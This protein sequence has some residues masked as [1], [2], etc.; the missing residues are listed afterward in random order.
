MA[1]TA[2]EAQATA[3]RQC[4][5][6]T[7]THPSQRSSV[8]V[9]TDRTTAPMDLNLASNI[10]FGAG[11]QENLQQIGGSRNV[12]YN[13]IINYHSGRAQEPTRTSPP[14]SSTVPFHR[15]RNFVDRPELEI[16][17]EKLSVW[18]EKVALVGIGGVGKSQLAIE[19]CYRVRERSPEVWTFWI[20]ASSA[21]RFDADIRKLACDAEIPGWDD[22]KADAFGLV[23]SWLRNERNGKW[24]LVLDNVDDASF[25][26]DK[27]DENDKNARVRMAY[28]PPCAHGS[29]LITS[30]SRAA[31]AR[32]ADECNIVVVNRMGEAAALALLEKKLGQSPAV[33]DMQK[34]ADA[35]GYMPLALAQAGAYIKQRGSSYSIGHYLTRFKKS[36]KSQT[37]LLTSG[38]KELRRDEEAQDSII[39]TWQISFDTIRATRPSAADLLSLMSMYNYQGIP[40]NLLRTRRSG[41]KPSARPPLG[42]NDARSDIDESPSASDDEDLE[43]D[44]FRDDIS[45]LENFLFIS[46]T[47]S[48]VAFEMHP[49]LQLAA[50]V[51]LRSHELYQEWA[52]KAIEQL[53]EALPNGDYENWGRCDE[54]YPHVQSTLGLQL[55]DREA[56][57]RRA[58][59]QYKAA[60]FDSTRGLWSKAKELAASCHNMRRKTLGLEDKETLKAQDFY[61]GV[62]RTQGNYKAA[63]ELYR[64]ALEGLEKGLGK[65]HLFTLISVNNLAGVLQV[66]GDYKA[67]EKL[68]RRALEGLE[69][70]LGKEHPDTLMSVNGLAQV[71]QVRGENEAAEKL[72]R[73]VLEGREKVLGKEHPYTLMS[74]NNL[75]E[76]LQV[77]GDYEATE[78]LH[79]RALEG[80][81]KVLGKEHPDT[82]TSVNNLAGVLQAQRDYEAAEK[83]YRQALEGREKVLGKEHPNTLMSVNNLAGVL[84]A[85][86]D[87]KAAETLHRHA[88]EGLEKGLGKEHPFTLT[89]VDNLV[90]VLHAQGDYVAAEKLLRRVLDG[91]EKV[92]GHADECIVCRNVDGMRRSEV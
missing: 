23:Y 50:R 53:D 4:I 5:V 17:D 27:R 52:R 59:I 45:T 92:L 37:R 73:Q 14:P 22:P 64:R 38:S 10:S 49:L 12:Q 91:S 57:L 6:K 11:G 88:L 48:N 43:E 90:A 15:D 81:E 18:N 24:I 83:L 47:F 1:S 9:A 60:W 16:L 65:E 42:P 2:Q 80:S 46:T 34:L 79:R 13:A 63:E 66:Q 40:E 3:T 44:E 30:R 32:L 89:S 31:A 72:H 82:L 77:Q 84:Q 75:A 70:V 36:E 8:D 26:F 76:V 39:L 55:D 41:T 74:V 56:S 51:W 69:K 61:A 58:T 33:E 78:K 20:H 71:L 86:G 87:Y 68:H 85:Q 54:L 25:L 21:A 28:L 35:L 67:A 29:T 7:E 19:F 62:L